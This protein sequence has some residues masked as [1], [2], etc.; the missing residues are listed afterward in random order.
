[1]DRER[2]ELV[3]RDLVR[4]RI[5]SL[6]YGASRSKITINEPQRSAVFKYESRINEVMERGVGLLFWG[7]NGVGKTAMAVVIAKEAAR[8][9]WTVLFIRAADLFD[10]STRKTWFSEQDG[11]SVWDRARSVDLLVL[12]DLGK[13][14]AD[15]NGRVI[16]DMEEFIR[17]RVSHRRVIIAT[18]NMHPSEGFSKIYKPSML[19]VMKEAIYPIQCEGENHREAIKE[20]IET[21]ISG[22]EG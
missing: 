1:M 3:E 6:F 19:E 9:G 2:R 21:L 12:D 17:D 5:P 16:R 22:E 11:V 4:M 18:T 8:F 20:S 13:E 15:Q 14:V 7:A 10:L